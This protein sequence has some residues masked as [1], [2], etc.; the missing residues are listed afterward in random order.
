M[1]TASADQ[2]RAL[3]RAF[4]GITWPAGR[5][6]VLALADECGWTVRLETP[7]GVRYDTG[8]PT[9]DQ[10]A[11]ALIR[12]DGADGRVLDLTVHV[13]DRDPG[14][15]AGLDEAYRDVAAAVQTELG[16]PVRTDAWEHARTVW[17][18]AGGGRVVVQKLDSVVL[19]LRSPEV[20]DLERDEERLGIDPGRVPGTGHEDL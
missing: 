8:L 1:Q 5:Q 15:P 7:R 6:K 4:R 13:S 19:V 2:I 12:P 18:I 9:N 10:R 20:A 16:E 14:T 11:S 3:L 17:D